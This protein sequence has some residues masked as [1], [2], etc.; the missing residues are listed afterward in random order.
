MEPY[1]DSGKW[2]TPNET[3][4]VARSP[5]L[6]FSDRVDRNDPRV[7]KVSRY[8]CLVKKPLNIIIAGPGIF[9][10]FK[11]DITPQLDVTRQKDFT[12]STCCVMPEVGEPRGARY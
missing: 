7:I 10:E 5:I 4:R 3:H 2:F 8:F 9:D 12:S 6:G 11:S 1:D